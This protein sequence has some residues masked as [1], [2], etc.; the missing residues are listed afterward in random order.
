MI[1]GFEALGELLA[2]LGAE[3]QSEP[4]FGSEQIRH[5]RPVVAGESREEQGRGA[6][7]DAV[8]RRTPSDLH[9]FAAW[10]NFELDARELPLLLKRFQEVGQS[11]IRHWL[12]SIVHERGTHIIEPG[13]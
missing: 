4:R 1:G 11:V 12:S 10:I 13:T 5:N 2:S 6:A 3:S 8:P 7:I 9:Q